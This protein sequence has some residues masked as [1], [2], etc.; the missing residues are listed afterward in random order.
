MREIQASDADASLPGWFDEAERGETVVIMR[1]GKPVA[2]IV[3]EAVRRREE[4][5]RAVEGIKALR[6]TSGKMTVE[7]I[8]A[9]KHEG[10]QY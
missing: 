10:H 5:E 1:D 6:K 8:I 3:P 2:R 4:I 9:A 7:E